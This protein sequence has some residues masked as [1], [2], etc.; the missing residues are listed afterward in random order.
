MAKNKTHIVRQPKAKGGNLKVGVITVEQQHTMRRAA[1]RQAEI[2]SGVKVG[3][4][5][6][7]HGDNKEQARRRDRREG[8]RA[9]RQEV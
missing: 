1:R 6:G 3:S 8:K 5:A 9:V 4:G 2:D 7:S